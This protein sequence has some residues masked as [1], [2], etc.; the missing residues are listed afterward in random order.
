MEMWMSVKITAFLIILII[1]IIIII[2][3][4][5]QINT[6]LFFFYI[7]DSVFSAGLDD[8]GAI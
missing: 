6:H 7:N 4:I 1:I 5:I 2:T 3:I 8:R